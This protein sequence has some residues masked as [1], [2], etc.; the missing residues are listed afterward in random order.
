MTSTLSEFMV[1]QV[2]SALTVFVTTQNTLHQLDAALASDVGIINLRA[3]AL[4]CLAKR[5][6]LWEESEVSREIYIKYYVL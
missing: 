5:E 1:F 4:W 3:V 6:R 2:Y